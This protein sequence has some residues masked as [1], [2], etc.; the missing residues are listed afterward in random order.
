MQP[1]L[2]WGYLFKNAEI[3]LLNL[4]ACGIT[5]MNSVLNLAC[6]A[7]VANGVNFHVGFF[8]K[9]VC[10]FFLRSEACGDYDCIGGDLLGVAEAVNNNCGV[11]F[12][13][14]KTVSGYDSY[15]VSAKS[16]EI[17]GNN[18]CSGRKELVHNLDDGY[19]FAFCCKF[20]SS[21]CTGDAAADNNSFV[22]FEFN[23]SA[24]IIH[25]VCN[26]FVINSRNV[27]LSGCAADCDDYCIVIFCDEFFCGCF[28][29]FYR[30]FCFFDLDFVI[31]GKTA[32]ICFVIRNGSFDHCAADASLFIKGNI[33]AAFFSGK[34]SFTA[35]GT[36]TDN[37][38][39]LGFFGFGIFLLIEFEESG[40]NSTADGLVSED[41]SVGAAD[42]AADAGDDIFG[43]AGF[44]F[45]G[46]CGVCKNL[47][48][49]TDEVCLA[50]C[51]NFFSTFGG[52]NR[53]GYHYGNVDYFLDFCGHFCAVCPGIET[54]RM[55]CGGVGCG[56]KVEK[57]NAFAFENFA[58]LDGFFKT[59][60]FGFAVVHAEFNA[61]G[62]VRA[63]IAFNASYEFNKESHSVMEGTAVHIGSVVIVRRKEVGGK[64]SAGSVD[65]N[66]LESG[67]FCAESSF[68]VKVCGFSKSG[69]TPLLARR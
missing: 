3:I 32:D 10:K 40:V 44:C 15:V 18:G 8:F 66:K 9:F 29:I 6:S 5:F 68:S 20:K 36:C 60:T 56:Y 22:A 67:V 50:F 24:E 48:C 59:D 27:E 30:D 43:M 61:Y 69:A 54:G 65:L 34:S 26:D 4:A 25:C 13:A 42:H 17:F 23:S 47:S 28:F 52:L 63:D 1:F 37:C 41:T 21:F 38:N 11:V 2:F 33:M 51:K 14:F 57:C 19:L 45:F 31:L 35:A 49:G 12:N 39:S 53:T 46:P 62:E 16:H 58:Y 7:A 55:V 64:A